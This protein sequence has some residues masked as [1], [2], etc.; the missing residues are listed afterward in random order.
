MPEAK[1]QEGETVATPD[2]LAQVEGLKN[3]VLHAEATTEEANRR[4]A[5]A[6][7]SARLASEDASAARAAAEAATTTSRAS[8]LE[9][10]NSEMTT[11]QGQYEDA[12]TAGD[13][14]AMSATQAK[15]AKLGGRIAQLETEKEAAPARPAGDTGRVRQPSNGAVDPNEA[16]LMTRT[17][18]TAAW[19]RQH[20]EF[21]RDQ[22]FNAKVR[23][24]DLE[25]ESEGKPKDTREYFDFIERKAGLV[26]EP[27]APARPAAEEPAPKPAA[28][29][30]VPGAGT[31]GTAATLT[32][33]GTGPNAALPDGRRTPPQAGR[34]RGTPVAAP[35]SREGAPALSGRAET[36]VKRITPEMQAWAKMM[37]PPT[38][39]NPD[40]GVDPELYYDEYVRM[41]EEGEI[42]DRFGVAK[43]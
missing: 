15:M 36:G 20:P 12:F 27:A 35:P 34:A 11:L 29:A 21:F 19:L 40:G 26:A 28:A 22:R 42:N 2:A 9:R 4:A 43:R 32:P 25:W 41:V 37:Y 24:A 38:K 13:A 1:P 17:A 6:A 33:A 10:A 31:E 39:D 7:E 16:F 23:A 18:P 30:A 14:K 5:M 8:E 3:R